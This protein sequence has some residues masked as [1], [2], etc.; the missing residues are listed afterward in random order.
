M[1]ELSFNPTVMKTLNRVTL[2]GNLTAD[3]EAKKLSDGL[4][5]V[6][7]SV[8]TERSWIGK[9]GETEKKTDFHR[10]SA[11]RKLAEICEKWLKKGSPIYLEGYIQNRS[12]ETESGQKRYLTEIVAT[13][14]F[15]LRFPPAA[16]V[17]ING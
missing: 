15:I 12:Y 2:L 4:N 8:A 3:P 13:E 17:A 5:L 10:V 6:T 1:I 11:W 16:D 9:Q 7:M 14:I